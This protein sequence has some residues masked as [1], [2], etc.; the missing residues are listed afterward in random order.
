[1][2]G[3][4]GTPFVSTDVIEEA[5]RY[6]VVMDVVFPDGAVR[7]RLQSYHTRSRAEAAA[8][9]FYRTA[10]REAPSGWGM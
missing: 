4:E 7:H 2:S 1:M 10:Q 8:K 9:M 5:G 3:D 6:T